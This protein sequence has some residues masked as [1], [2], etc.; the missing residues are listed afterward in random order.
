MTRVL[1]T[2]PWPV[3]SVMVGYVFSKNCLANKGNWPYGSVNVTHVAVTFI[4]DA[5]PKLHICCY[6]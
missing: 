6:I 2:E 1:S 4:S 5:S 3:M